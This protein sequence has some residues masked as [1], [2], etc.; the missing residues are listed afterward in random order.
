MF[1][2]E[3]RENEL[4]ETWQRFVQGLL[5]VLALVGAGVMAQYYAPPETSGLEQQVHQLSRQVADLERQQSFSASAVDDA[6]DSVAYIYGIY[7]VSGHAHSQSFRARV[8]GTGFVVAPGLLATNRHVAEPWYGDREVEVALRNGGSPVLE[9]LVAYFPGSPLPVNLEVAALA[10]Q[11]D[12]AVLRLEVTAF[13]KKLRPLT[14][15]QVPPHVGDS[16]SVLAYPMGVTGMV[17]KSPAVVYQRLSSH[18]D[19]ANTAGELAALS[20][21]RPSATFG[22]IGDVTGDKLIYDAPTAR[23]GSGGP[24]LNRHGEV[25]GINSAYIDGFSGGTLGI[26]TGEL[27]PLIETAKHATLETAAV[28]R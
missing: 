5:G 6:R 7:H 14:L 26:T 20:L 9:K 8:A 25:V 10:K 22:H 2:S 4:V 21:I 1:N 18:P 23:G 15:A 28:V 13:T 12:L 24:V 16:V 19:D 3:N 27:R 17:A 11:G